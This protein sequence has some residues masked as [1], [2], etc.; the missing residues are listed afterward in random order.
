MNRKLASVLSSQ[1]ERILHRPIL[2][3]KTKP[4]NL[5]G[6]FQ[7][8]WRYLLFTNKKLYTIDPKTYDEGNI[9]KEKLIVNAIDVEY[10]SHLIFFPDFVFDCY[11]YFDI[12][13]LVY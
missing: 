3:L 7:K 1:E 5:L 13:K 4:K 2:V 9:D 6:I 10:L 11:E 12:K 8:K